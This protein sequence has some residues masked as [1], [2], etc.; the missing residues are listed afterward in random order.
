MRKGRRAVWIA[1]KQTSSNEVPSCFRW[2]IEKAR[3][4]VELQWHVEVNSLNKWMSYSACKGLE[5]WRD[6]MRLWNVWQD[7]EME[8]WRDEK[9]RANQRRN[10]G[11]QCECTANCPRLAWWLDSRCA[12][13]TRMGNTVNIGQAQSEIIICYGCPRHES[14]VFKGKANTAASQ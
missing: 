13:S 4:A 1:D 7:G 5:R 8:R 6:L 9:T 10:Y 12:R 3:G 14:C 2:T 11:W